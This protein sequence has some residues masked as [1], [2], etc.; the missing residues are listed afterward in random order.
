MS[1]RKTKKVSQ[2]KVAIASKHD[3]AFQEGIQA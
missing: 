3:E 2:Q 1:Q